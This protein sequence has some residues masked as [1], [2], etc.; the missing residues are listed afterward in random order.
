MTSPADGPLG[1][2]ALVLDD[3]TARVLNQNDARPG[4]LDEL[5][6]LGPFDAQLLQFSGA[7]WFPIAYDFPPAEK[8]RLARDEAN[9]RDGPGRALRRGGRRDPRVPVRG[10]AVLPRPR[11]LHA[12]RPRP[13]S[14]QHLP[15]PARVPRPPRRARRRP[16]APRRARVGRDDRGRAHARLRHP[17]P[18]PDAVDPFPTSARTSI[19][20]NATGRNG[21]GRNARVGPSPASTSWAKSRHW[22]EPLLERAPITSAGIAGNVVLDVGDPDGQPLHRLR[23]VAGSG[24]ARRPVGLQGRRR[25]RARRAARRRPRRGLGQFA[26][27]LLSL[28]R[29]PARP[30]QR[31]R[32]DVLQG[33]LTRTDRLRG[34]LPPGGAAGAPT[35]T[36]NATAGAS[37][38]G[39]RIARPTSA[40]SARSPTACSRA[41][42]TIGG[43]TSRPVVASRVTTAICAVSAWRLT[44]TRV[45]IMLV[46]EANREADIRE[47]RRLPRPGRASV[48]V[49]MRLGEPEADQ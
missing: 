1:D 46:S 16:R 22:F 32:H 25:P 17:A 38:V 44:D 26:V 49:P 23:R 2:S 8:D 29:P 7:I 40:A 15:R 20:I 14:R 13:R 41:A 19:A 33:A 4:D 28:H 42:S 5:R 18:P 45:R 11:P 31:V 24:L 47:P 43:S 48:G 36:S 12:E 21:S 30:V 6:E 10:P 27:P 35:S 34:A 3:G 37:S 9:R 39:A